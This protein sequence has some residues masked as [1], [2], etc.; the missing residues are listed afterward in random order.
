MGPPSSREPQ[1]P[2]PR[3]R[4]H[5]LGAPADAEWL[6]QV[7]VHPQPPAPADSPPAPA[8]LP[9]L[10]AAYEADGTGLQCTEAFGQSVPLLD[11]ATALPGAAR[12]EASLQGNWQGEGA[13]SQRCLRRQRAHIS[14]FST[15][16]LSIPRCLTL[17]AETW[18]RG[19]YRGALPGLDRQICWLPRRLKAA[20]Q[21]TGGNGPSLPCSSPF[22][23]SARV[24]VVCV[25]EPASLLSL[26][27][28]LCL[29]TIY[30]SCSSRLKLFSGKAPEAALQSSWVEQSKAEKEKTKMC[31]HFFLWLGPGPTARDNGTKT[32][33]S[34]LFRPTG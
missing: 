6:R 32:R 21:R 12:G 13:G 29:T 31:L 14:A 1:Q 4:D 33:E 23:G 18:G 15:T 7:L 10:L 30:F 26:F 3:P 24:Q 16:P 27:T 22:T 9:C 20:V 28:K 2:R 19:L 25:G 34:K 8:Q 11:V 5:V 17:P